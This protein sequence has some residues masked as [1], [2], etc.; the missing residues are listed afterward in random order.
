MAIKDQVLLLLEKNKNKALSGEEMAGMLNCTRAAVGK[1]VNELRANGYRIEAAN[2]KGYT[3][4]NSG[5]CLKQ[6]LVQE[7]LN[8]NLSNIKLLCVDTIDSTNSYLKRLVA[9][10]E[11]DDM[12]VVSGEQTAGRGRRGRSFFSPE[13]TGLYMSFLLHPKCKAEEATM[14][15]TIAAVAEAMAIEEV[16]G[17][18]AEIK[19]VNDLVLRH[20]KISGI[21]TEAATSMEDGGLDYCIVGI[22]IN[23]YDP[24]EGWPMEIKDLAGS[25]LGKSL[26]E[27]Q[28]ENLKNNVAAT[29][30]NR[31]M[32]FYSSFPGVAYL[33]EYEKRCFCIGKEVTIMTSDHEALAADGQRPDRS[34]ALVLGV[35]DRCHLH[36][37]YRDGFEEFLSSGEISIRL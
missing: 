37:R 5:D 19:W 8:S 11:T 3:L 34:R 17:E 30:I 33:E 2:K 35:N 21:L 7:K 1:A 12:I 18:K 4:L 27:G 31:F 9:E 22:G 26:L 23:L 16:T 10:G 28:V 36:V 15:T 24:N 32:E 29:L 20:K 6:S 13:G 14:L 25:V